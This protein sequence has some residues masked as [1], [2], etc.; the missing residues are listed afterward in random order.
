MD[1][2]IVTRW[3]E[4]SFFLVVNAGCKIQDLD[5]MRDTYVGLAFAILTSRP[6]GTAGLAATEIMAELSPEANSLVFMHGCHSSHRW[7]RML[8]HQLWLHR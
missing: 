4:N 1:D 5:H 2:L 8:Y 7:H 3:A 6:T